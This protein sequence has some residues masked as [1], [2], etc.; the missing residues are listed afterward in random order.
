MPKDHLVD[1]IAD[2]RILVASAHPLILAEAA[3]ETRLLEVVRRV[4]AAE[5]IPVWTWTASRG[6]ARDGARPMY[7]TTDPRSALAFISDLPGPGVFVLADAHPALADPL[8]LR[9]VKDVALG[10]GARQTLILTAPHQDPPPE[11]AGLAL[12]WRLLPPDDAELAR[13]VRRTVE[14]LTMRAMVAGI[15][16]EEERS[17][18]G[19]LRGLTLSDAERVL[20][21]A[22]L[23]DGRLESDDVPWVRA[24]KVEILNADGILELIESESWALDTVGG[25][26]ALKDWLALR[27]RAIDEPEAARS[28]GID[29]ARGILL[30]G[31]PGCGKSLVAKAVAATWQRPLVGLDPSRIYDKYVGESERRLWR[32][33]EAAGAMA[34]I[35]LWIDEIEKGFATG[36]EGD[37][38]VS[39]RMLGSFLRWMQDRPP[40]VFVVATAND[41][42]LL[43]PEFLRK[44]RFDEVFFVDLPAAGAR[45]AILEHHLRSRTQDPERFDVGALVCATEGFSG[46]EIEAVVVGA[47]YRAFATGAPLQTDDLLAEAT[48][49]V[50]LSRSRSGDIAELRRWG[51]ANA[52][53]AER[54]A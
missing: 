54:P 17:L 30:T 16:T 18:V 42:G 41:I 53:Q 44:G 21:R 1:A 47:L 6:L 12:P 40:G 20:Q 28:A 38:G 4:A 34:P 15:G 2:L 52:V 26:E 14:D 10:L 36:G 9:T 22:V 7:G 24:A 13:L 32:A 5:S 31:V 33:L 3:E 46:A 45:R 51:R 29:P 25:L 23:R 27:T 39:R 37:G 8:T 50:P 35:V 48:S 19:A 11:L 49:T 43:P